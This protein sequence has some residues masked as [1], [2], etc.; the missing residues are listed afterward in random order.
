QPVIQQLRT[1]AHRLEPYT[2]MH[3]DIPKLIERLRSAQIELQ[4]IADEA[5][6][7]SS[8]I[9]FDPN[10]IEILQESLYEGYGLLKKH[11][12]KTTSELLEVQQN[13][14]RKLDAVLHIDDDVHRLDQMIKKLFQN[15]QSLS[16]ELFI[17]RK[18]QAPAAEKNVNKMLA[19]I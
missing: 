18:K 5:G 13:L 8:K 2:N 6:Y 3:G 12:V 15:L 11:G 7:I 1:M 17:Q 19:Q 4:D 10:R 9:Q 16:D 14:S